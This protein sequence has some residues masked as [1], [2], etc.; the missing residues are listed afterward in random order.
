MGIGAE[1]TFF[2]K[3]TYRWPMAVIKNSTNTITNARKG[4]EKR[5]SSYPVGGNVN[6]CSY[7]GK[8]YGGSSEN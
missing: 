5:E 3:K 2:S 4:V 8:P 7:C 6:W 1:Q